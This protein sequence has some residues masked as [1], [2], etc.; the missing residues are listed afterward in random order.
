MDRRIP[1]NANNCSKRH[2]QSSTEKYMVTT[3]KME[4]L[5]KTKPRQLEMQKN[6]K[7]EMAKKQ[8]KERLR[9]KLRRQKQLRIQ[10]LSTSLS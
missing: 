6:K 5:V 4:L 1:H 7:W 3:R 9:P 2:T 8:R 10:E